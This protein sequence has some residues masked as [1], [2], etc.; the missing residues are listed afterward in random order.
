MKL[1]ELKQIFENIQNKPVA[2]NVIEGRKQ[3]AYQDWVKNNPEIFSQIQSSRY[4]SDLNAILTAY[5]MY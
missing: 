5:G 2:M 1:D 4:V 3:R